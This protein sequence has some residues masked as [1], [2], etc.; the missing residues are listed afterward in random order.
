MAR[1]GDTVENPVT[2]ERFTFVLTGRETD[3]EL[4]R[5]DFSM[6]AGGFVPARHIHPRQEE[7][8]TIVAGRLRFWRDGRTFDAA[9]GDVVAVPPGAAH[10]LWNPTG[11]EA[12]VVIEF[13]PAGR[14][15]RALEVLCALGRAGGLT[16]RGIPRNPLRAAV[17]M[18]DTLD[19][20]ILVGVPPWVQRAGARGMMA[21]GRLLGYRPPSDP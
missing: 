19:D 2:G 8:F 11:A 18:G 14:Q 3:G 1:P 17:L 9:D 6:R 13:R 15:E 7:R 5:I 21:A 16:R 12:R 10:R 4:L 20:N